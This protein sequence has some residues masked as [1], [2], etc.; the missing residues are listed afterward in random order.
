[1]L[2]GHS[3]GYLSGSFPGRPGLWD[4]QLLRYLRDELHWHFLNWVKSI[5]WIHR[6]HKGWK[7]LNHITWQCVAPRGDAL[8][9]THLAPNLNLALGRDL[10]YQRVGCYRRPCLTGRPSRLC[11]TLSN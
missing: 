3:T 11:S 2:N 8:T 6:P 10:H 1:M 9:A 4:T 7:Q 5:T